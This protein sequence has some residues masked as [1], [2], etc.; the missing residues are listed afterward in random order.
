[1]DKTGS[2]QKIERNGKTYLLLKDFEKM[3]QGVGMLEAE[4]M[5]I[6]A[7]G[8][9]AAIKAL[10]DKYA[11]HFD[12]ALRESASQ[13]CA[14]YL[15][16]V[17]FALVAL[18][19]QQ[20][21]FFAGAGLL[22]LL[23]NVHLVRVFFGEFLRSHGVSELHLVCLGIGLT[24]LQSSVLRRTIRSLQSIA[25]INLASLGLAC[26]VLV[27]LSA[28]YFNLTDLVQPLMGGN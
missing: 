5:R 3:R 27:Q 1:M 15:G 17:A 4:L 6:K 20:S 19:W 2:I 13:L 22:L 26:S 18:F 24:L 7:E 28:N 16:T 9:Y 12:P 10:V 23:G 25:A 14:P 11:V 8:D 21:G